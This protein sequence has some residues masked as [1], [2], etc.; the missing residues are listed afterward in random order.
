M[1]NQQLGKHNINEAD[2]DWNGRTP[3]HWACSKGNIDCAKVLLLSGA[4]LNPKMHGGWTPAHCAAETGKLQILKLLQT[5]KAPLNLTDDY[6]DSPRRIAQTYGH[7][8]CEQF[9]IA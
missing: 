3:L 7:S 1:L 8:E 2:Q 5:Y 9:L 6:G 4:E